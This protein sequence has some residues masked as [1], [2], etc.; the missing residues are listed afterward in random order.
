MEYVPTNHLRAPRN[1]A[2]FEKELAPAYVKK[3]EAQSL[4]SG[5]VKDVDGTLSRR[6]EKRLVRVG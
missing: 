1:E 4:E 2:L 5:G 3:G 6:H